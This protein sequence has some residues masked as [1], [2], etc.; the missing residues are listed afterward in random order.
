MTYDYRK[1]KI[2]AVINENLPTW[3]MLNVIGHLSISLGAHKDEDL[4]GESIL[5]DASN[6]EHKGIARYGFIIKKGSTENIRDILKNA[7]DTKEITVIDFPRE[8]LE[9]S[10]DDSLVESMS[11]KEEKDFEYFGI[12][13]YGPSET[14]N[15]LTKGVVMFS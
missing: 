1:Q 12:L 8:M 6:I 14:V 13:I 9:I 5:I 2:V 15:R 11:K 3:Q 4:M 7:K 10:D